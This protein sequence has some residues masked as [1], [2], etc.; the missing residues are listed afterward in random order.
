PSPPLTWGE[1]V[2]IAV[3]LLSMP[4]GEVTVKMTL[5]GR[6]KQVG[7]QKGSIFCIMEGRGAPS[8]LPKGLPLPPEGV[9][10]NIVV[11]IAEK[12][13]SKVEGSLKENKEDALIIEG[14]PYFDPARQMT[15]L[16]AQSTTTKF[17][18]RAKR[19]GST[20]GAE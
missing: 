7:K 19:Q 6:P 1:A 13:W 12:Q 4:K 16:L 18:Q 3:K 11:F 14:W 10:Q 15:V 9:K 5:I 2:A 20:S 17:I 8:A